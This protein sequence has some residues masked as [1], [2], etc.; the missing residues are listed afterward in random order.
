MK[1]VLYYD[2][3]SPPVRSVLM[4]LKILKIDLDLKFIDLFK[5]EQLKPD[6]KELN[7]AHTVP[8]LVDDDLVLTDSHVILM[9]L[10]EKYQKDNLKLWPQ[11][12]KERMQVTNMLLFEGSLIFRRDSEMMSEIV[13]KTY[14]NVDIPY[15]QRKMHEIY[16]MCE[17]HLKKHKYLATDYLTIA[18]ISAVTTLSTVDLMYPI[19]G[20][21]W[22]SLSTWLSDM[23][24]MPEYEINQKGLQELKDIIEQYGKFKF[25]AR[26]EDV[27]ENINTINF[28]GK[29]GKNAV[30]PRIMD[31]EYSCTK[32]PVLY[33]D[34]I[35][36]HARS[37]QMLIKLLKIDVEL[38][39]TDSIS[40]LNFYDTYTWINSFCMLPT[41]VDGNV[42]LCNGHS[43][44]IYLCEKYAPLN[45]ANVCPC[46]YISRLR[47]M[48]LLFYEGCIL[49]RR[50]YHL[51][52][53]IFLAKYPNFDVD[54]HKHKV[55]NVFKT[56]N[57]FLKG[58]SFMIG[59]H[60]TIA[61]IS[62]VSTVSALNI[63][64]P[65]D[66]EKF[67]RLFDWLQ[68][69]K[70]MEFY[71]YNE[72]GI[73]KLRYLL[74]NV[75][76]FPFPSPFSN[77][78]SNEE[79]DSEKSD[80]QTIRKA[81]EQN[82]NE[83]DTIID[84]NEVLFRHVDATQKTFESSNVKPIYN[85][86]AEASS[87]SFENIFEFPNIR[88]H[89]PEKINVY[90]TDTKNSCNCNTNNF[91]MKK[92]DFKKDNEIYRR[93]EC[94]N[95][96]N[97]SIEQE[98]GI[99]SPTTN[100]TICGCCYS[101]NN[102]YGANEFK[103][104]PTVEN[105]VIDMKSCIHVQ[106]YGA[107]MDHRNCRPS[108]SRRKEG[109][110]RNKLMA[111]SCFYN[112]ESKNIPKSDRRSS[113]N[114][115]MA[116]ETDIEN[117]ENN[118]KGIEEWDDMDLEE[119]IEQQS[120]KC[121]ETC[122]INKPFMNKFK[123]NK[124]S[125]FIT[126]NANKF[127][128]SRSSTPFKKYKNNKNG[129]NGFTNQEVK[130]LLA[131]IRS[132]E[133]ILENTTSEMINKNIQTNL[134]RLNKNSVIDT[135]VS[136]DSSFESSEEENLPH[137]S[138][139]LNKRNTNYGK[140]DMSRNNEDPGFTYQD[141]ENLLEK[142][143]YFEYILKTPK[144]EV[145]VSKSTQMHLPKFGNKSNRNRILD[146][147]VSDDFSVESLTEEGENF[148]NDYA[149]LVPE[150]SD[151]ILM[152]KNLPRF[153]NNFDKSP[154][155][156]TDTSKDSSVEPPTEEDMPNKIVALEFEKSEL[157]EDDSY[158]SSLN[159][160]ICETGFIPRRI[161]MPNFVVTNSERE[162]QNPITSNNSSPQSPIKET[163]TEYPETHSSGR[164]CSKHKRLEAGSNPKPRESLSYEDDLPMTS[165]QF[166]QRNV[167]MEDNVSLDSEKLTKVIY[168]L[169]MKNTSKYRNKC[170][171]D[172]C[173]KKEKKK[174]NIKSKIP[175]LIANK[176]M[177]SKSSRDIGYNC[178]NEKSLQ[179]K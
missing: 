157:E 54:S 163:T 165:A 109:Y 22:P 176:T 164:Y 127:E 102:V 48:S 135:K 18:D 78:P 128:I 36:S 95:C 14:A 133:K 55:S 53:D 60:L 69:I 89:N 16:D 20:A 52:T 39:S 9:H 93:T 146:T 129:T 25:P 27:Q 44:L 40:D 123:P 119:D 143:R 100:Y 19:A 90:N 170:P 71:N 43:I 88:E 99:L 76:K 56:L 13:R 155:V 6:F 70:K 110:N 23:K 26:E 171:C 85:A 145:M 153:S 11:Q 4:L 120:V 152:D 159:D 149:I 86:D 10:C 8:T 77:E 101:H 130:N 173:L 47:L 137:N 38:R 150:L 91:P 175:L 74:K 81:D 132:L 103:T 68:R 58:Q 138:V 66:Y 108:S 61:D 7:P 42:T 3:R 96:N 30:I 50:L 147:K 112:N 177:S 106:Y 84:A 63:I 51:L 80:G 21:Q 169:C 151:K 98:N 125:E 162:P 121:E 79:G 5:G 116:K 167:G 156:V 124:E 126:Q 41:L 160:K 178:T 172:D 105:P 111:C 97:I 64:F 136:E 140:I 57:T 75:G 45:L 166:K 62:C 35:N 46:D 83:S 82:N 37:C 12:Y 94:N 141:I 131:K 87:D 2:Q 72:E 28:S 139:I 144:S 114:K 59:N 1:L 115:C 154:V 17:V 104:P 142:F 134:P 158:N 67:P 168:H 179:N 24:S 92:Q 113:K 34:A 73:Q 15:H 118:K 65:I 49:F 32:V 107:N 31:H 29:I 33:Y 161:L 174:L 122:S 117:S 148:A